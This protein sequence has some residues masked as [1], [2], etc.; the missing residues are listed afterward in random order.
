AAR[1]PGFAAADRSPA[2]LRLRRGGAAVR[3]RRTVG[4]VA[5]QQSLQRG[6]AG[7]RAPARPA[8]P[9]LTRAPSAALRHRPPWAA[10]RPAASAGTYTSVLGKS[11]VGKEQRVKLKMA[12]NSLFAIL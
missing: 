2:A 5:C 12:E 11:G 8:Q 1:L 6:V 4:A 9:R 10:P 3:R 7:R